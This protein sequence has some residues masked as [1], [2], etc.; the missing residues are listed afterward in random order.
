MNQLLN[1]LGYQWLKCNDD[2]VMPAR[3]TLRVRG[4]VISDAGLASGTIQ[5]VRDH[6]ARTRCDVTLA[7]ADYEILDPSGFGDADDVYITAEAPTRI[8]GFVYDGVAVK[9]K[10][11]LNAGLDMFTVVN[12]PWL[13]DLP[14]AFDPG[15]VIGCKPRVLQPGESCRI[16]WDP[17]WQ[18]WLVNDGLYSAE[19]VTHDS[20][21]VTHDSTSITVP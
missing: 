12:Y 4:G 13:E 10:L 17:V 11:I 1:A 21:I 7:S 2:P 16:Q 14:S 18:L 8:A 5:I 3:G 9:T 19:L 15:H 20:E 6:Y